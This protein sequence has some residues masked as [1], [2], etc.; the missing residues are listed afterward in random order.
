MKREEIAD[1]RHDYGKFKLD[2]KSICKNPFD[3]FKIWFDDAVAA[4]FTD[5]NA[6]NL[7]T[8]A[9]NGRPSSRIVLLKGYD[10]TGFYFYTNYESRKGREL[11]QNPFASLLFFWDKHER[12]VRIEGKCEKLKPAESDIYFQS[13]PYASRVGA[14]ASAQS[15][16]LP[17]RFGLMRKVAGLMLK[18][19]V[20]VP[21]PP[22]WG[23]YRLRPDA[24]EF[25]QGRES[26]LHD[27]FSFLHEGK[28]WKIDRL[29]P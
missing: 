4:Q 15:Q 17:S 23:G 18:H 8:V 16:V 25:W 13:R 14:W 20:N 24:F 12:Q 5:P 3:Q 19:P 1:I 9:E 29:S 2:E 6:M 28:T 21:L 7:S 22:F 26:R 11:E 27:R 10:E